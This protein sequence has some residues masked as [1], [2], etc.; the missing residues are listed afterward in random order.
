MTH[1]DGRKSPEKVKALVLQALD[2]DKALEIEMIDLRGQTSLADFMVVASGTSS[3]HI[4]ALAVKLTERLHAL[5]L[6][7]VRIEGM[8]NC[9]WVIVDAGDVII[10]LFKPEVRAF[11]NLEKMWRA[12]HP[13]IEVVHA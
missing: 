7:D 8:K 5:G 9:D 13:A 10:H 4:S 6:K 11:Y 2:A 3:R 12:P 1:D